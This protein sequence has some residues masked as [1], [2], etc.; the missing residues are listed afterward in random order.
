MIKLYGIPLSN[1]TNMVKTA[2]IEKAIP[3]EMVSIRPS[4]DASYLTKSKMGKVPCIETEDGFLAETHPILDYLEELKPQP[5]LLPS[6]AFE[7]AK[8]RELVQTLELYVEV[9]AHKGIGFMFGRPVPEEVKA[10]MKSDLPRGVAAVGRLARF[11]P[12]IAGPQFT[13]ADLFGYYT[14]SLA[15]LSAKKNVEMDLVTMLPGA[16]EWLQRV[17]ARDSIKKANADM[18]EARAALQR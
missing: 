18:A 10:S 6:T 5:A 3:F 4:Q 13:Y 17:G 8:V 1:Y 9:V 7:R 16:E 12:W 14:F 15:N 11:S 2:L